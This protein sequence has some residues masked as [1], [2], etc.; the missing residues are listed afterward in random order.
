MIGSRF[1]RLLLDYAAVVGG[2]AVCGAALAFFLIPND[3]VAGGVTGLAIL[4]SH[5]TSLSTGL[6]LVLLNLPILILARMAGAGRRLFLRTA[7]GVAVLSLSTD[8]L[9][10]LDLVP[11][12]DR[13]LLVFYGGLISGTGLGLV[14]LGRGT[15]GGLDVLARLAQRWIGVGVGQAIL[16]VNVVVFGLAAL[17]FG[18][19]AAAVALLLSFVM[20]RSLDAVLHGV[21]STRTAFIVTDRPG[22]VKEAILNH[23]GRGLTEFKGRGGYSG[24]TR[25]MLMVVV[26]RS[27]TRRLKFRVSQADPDA[28]VT[29][30]T[31][32]EV[33][34]G[35]LLPRPDQE[36]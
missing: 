13:L 11:T 15:T 25:T 8:L 27:D 7:V 19:E 35:F 6:A 5:F 32:R 22:P 20:S 4:I 17:V 2:A 36:L 10:S 16:A 18:F 33:Q 23:L 34:G 21:S 3:I 14:F 26:G 31:P 12:R 24:R 30:Y 9:L 28:F 1:L 29:I